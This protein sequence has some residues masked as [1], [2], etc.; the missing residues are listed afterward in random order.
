MMFSET[1]ILK[2]DVS[3]KNGLLAIHL[4]EGN[5]CLGKNKS[6]VMGLLQVLKTVE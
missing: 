2:L 3:V 5:K 4:Y 1:V 6:F